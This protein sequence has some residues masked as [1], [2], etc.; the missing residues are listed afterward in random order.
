MAQGLAKGRIEGPRDGTS[1]LKTKTLLNKLLAEM[2]GQKVSQIAKDGDRN[3]FMTANEALKYG[4]I[5]QVIA[6]RS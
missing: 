4:L 5:D 6:K 3:F 2:T 1:I